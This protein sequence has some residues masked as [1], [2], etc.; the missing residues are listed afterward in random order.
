MDRRA[1]F[2]QG[3]I[4]ATS[5]LAGGVIG[6]QVRPAAARDGHPPREAPGTAEFRAR[7]KEIARRQRAQTRATVER[8]VA[9]Y[10][11]P[12]FGR[13]RVWDLIEKLALCIDP[14]DQSLKCASQHLH[15][16]QM[17][18]AMER[19]GV[20]DESLVLAA[21]VH[22]LGKVALLAGEVPEHVVCYIAPVEAREPAAGL[23]S[24]LF[25]FGHDEIAYMRLKDHVPDEVA[26]LI[27]YHSMTVAKARPY[28]DARDLEYEARYLR[29]FSKYDGGSKSPAFLPVP[30]TLE[31][32]RDRIE[33]TFPSPILF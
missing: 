30:A 27:R 2:R 1:W 29:T 23:A 13:V 33:R 6:H 22:D 10:E 12:I 7:A 9:K 8:L 31:R 4:G 20:T 21:L 3:L 14:T 19:D 5:A 16:C 28:M 26:W 17:L 18:A 24:V 32:Y 15:V 11:R 25:R